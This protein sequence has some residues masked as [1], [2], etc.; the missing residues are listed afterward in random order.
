MRSGRR[1][2]RAGTVPRVHVNVN[3]LSPPRPSWPPADA[4]AS[5]RVY[6]R[7]EVLIMLAGAAAASGVVDDPHLFAEAF[8]GAYDRWCDTP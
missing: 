8:L 7:S 1:A 6:L 3:D 5:G 2:E 4:D